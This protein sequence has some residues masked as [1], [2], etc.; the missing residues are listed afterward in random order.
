MFTGII[1]EVGVVKR[2]VN[3]SKDSKEITIECN[4][5]IGDIKLG[6]SLAV[7]GVCLTIVE[8]KKN[9]VTVEA[10]EETVKKTTIG[11]FKPGTFVN[12]ER[13][14]QLSDR[15]GGHLVQGHVDSI[16]RVASI[17]K[18]PMGKIYRFDLSTGLMKYLVPVG[19][20]SINGVSL[21]V[22]EKLAD[23]IKVAIIPHTF[24][25][26]TFKYLRVGDFVNIEVDVIAKYVESLLDRSLDRAFLMKT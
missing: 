9:Y 22:A 23:S 8:K 18:L 24:E 26:T 5:V 2:V 16:G 11:S 15:V 13:A 19:S 7:D 1:E 20:V 6:D 14:M 4:K 25:S 17:T 3:F 21:T 10:V 12:L